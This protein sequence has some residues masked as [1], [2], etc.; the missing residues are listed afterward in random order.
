M[1]LQDLFTRKT[2][3]GKAIYI[4]DDHHKALAAWAIERR[5][6][7]TRLNLL[8]IDHHT[9]VIEAFHGHACVKAYKNEGVDHLALEAELLGRLDF[10]D[11]ESLTQAIELLR[12]DEHIHAA[13]M[14]GILDSA[15]CIQLSDHSGVRSIEE[16][17]HD[18]LRMKNFQFWLPTAPPPKRPMTYA[19]TPDRI[20]VVSHDCAIGCVKRPFDDECE[21]HN[22]DEI[23][24]SPYL[25]DQLDRISEIRVSLAASPLQEA[26]YILDIDLDVFHTKKAI[27]P[28][29]ATTF[30]RLVRNAAAI[31][32]ATEEECVE[33]EW[34]DEDNHL[35]AAELLHRVLKHIE[36]AL[37]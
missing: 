20:Y 10:N 30:Y 24:D 21:V 27:E 15:F 34:L 14:S 8:T 11:D 25:Q 19:A 35:D 36:I 1:A 17:V 31:T 37:A 3:A 5:R 23:L 26:P 13:T 7:G 32:I 22:A 28:N 33:V 9:D 16:I 2:V 6:L 18:E 12:H 29:D 4:V